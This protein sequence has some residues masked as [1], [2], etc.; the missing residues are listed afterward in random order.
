MIA[1]DL[2]SLRHLRMFEAVA[3]LESLSRA[4]AE[5]SRSQPAVTQ[6]LAN[7]EKTLGATLLERRHSGS[8]LTQ[9][10]GILHLRTQRLISQIRQAL[11][12][13]QVGPPFLDKGRLSSLEHKITSTH[14]RSLVAL[15][16]SS[17]IEA[18]ARTVDVTPRS[19]CRSVSDLEHLLGHPLTHHTAYGLTT[20]LGGAEL[21]RR[22]K[23][24]MREIEH[25]RD[26]IG[27]VCGQAETRISVGAI[28]QCSMYILSAAVDDLLH[29][30]PSAQ[31][32]IA[33]GPYDTLLNDLRTGRIDFLFGILR[34][35]D[36]VRDVH[37]EPLFSDPYSIVVRTGHPLT[38]KRE[39]R[40]EDLAAYDWILPRPGA[41]RRRAF[42]WMFSGMSR[43]PTS[44][45]ETSALDVQVSLIAASDRITLMSTQ[46]ARR[47][48][49][50]GSIVALP[51]QPQ[52]ARM[53]DG[54]TTR[55]DWHPTSVQLSFLERL[56]Q[57]AGRINTPAVHPHRGR[58][59]GRKLPAPAA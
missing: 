43:Q 32:M 11:L 9:C 46:E 44:R 26:E 42:E 1:A 19:L 16:E 53:L 21:A 10:G 57:H 40:L 50:G 2:P 29:Q 6:A 51:F 25:A 22:L 47:E 27:M 30:Y 4:A 15:A 24:A 49:A 23:L 28:P 52:V 48:S 54:V 56:R 45:V 36:W 58:R 12:K 59:M 14:V 41:P 33:D 7:L 8:Y 5:V 31:V 38:R 37:E 18:A 34:R 3:R 39:L 20:T 13:P 55:A 17:S 35:P